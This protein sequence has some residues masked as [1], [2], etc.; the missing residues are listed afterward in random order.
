MITNK[1]VNGKK[2]LTFPVLKIFLFFHST[3]PDRHHASNGGLNRPF[4][5]NFTIAKFIKGFDAT[6]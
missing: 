5:T 6:F 1:K 4:K 2:K 3:L